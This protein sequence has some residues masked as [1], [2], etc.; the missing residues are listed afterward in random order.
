[1]FDS[2]KLLRESFM[3]DCNFDIELC[4]TVRSLLGSIGSSVGFDDLSI[5]LPSSI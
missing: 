5:G 2:P 3:V 4:L 1:M